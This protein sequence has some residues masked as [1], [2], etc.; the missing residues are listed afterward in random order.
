M[1]AQSRDRMTTLP[2]EAAWEAYR[3]Y[4]RDLLLQCFEDA[5][6]I[7]RRRRRRAED[8]DDPWVVERNS[9]S[10]KEDVHLTVQLLF[11]KRCAPYKF[12]RDEFRAEQAL[13]KRTGGSPSK[14]SA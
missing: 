1:D 7:A 8:A 9:V 11:E 5:E 3:I 6:L 13:A 12:F 2:Q 14:A 10:P 4:Q